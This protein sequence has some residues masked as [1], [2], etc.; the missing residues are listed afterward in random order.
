MMMRSCHATPSS[1]PA[2]PAN[3]ANNA[4]AGTCANRQAVGAAGETGET[5]PAVT[6]PPDLA[7]RLGKAD[8]AVVGILGQAAACDATTTTA[9]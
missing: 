6:L 5:M 8:P 2:N 3:M 9:P 4:V 7:A 1:S